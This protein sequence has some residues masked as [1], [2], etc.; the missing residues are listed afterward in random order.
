M[1]TDRTYVRT[2]QPPLSTTPE[3][4][5]QK[6]IIFTITILNAGLLLVDHI[7]FQYNGILIGLLILTFDY[8]VREQY[9]LMTITFSILLLMKHL[10]V[11]FVPIFGLFLIRNYCGFRGFDSRI[12]GSRIFGSVR[13]SLVWFTKEGTHNIHC[14]NNKKNNLNNENAYGEKNNKT[15]DFKINNIDNDNKSIGNDEIHNV[16]NDGID[17][18][19][20]LLDR[21]NESDGANDN[22]YD[23]RSTNDTINSTKEFSSNN[24]NE[25]NREIYMRINAKNNTRINTPNNNNHEYNQ[26]TTGLFI[27]RCSHLVFIALIA[28]FLA[29]GPFILNF[30]VIVKNMNEYWYKTNSPINNI[31]FLNLN[32]VM[33]KSHPYGEYCD[34]NNPLDKC[35]NKIL[36]VIDHNQINQIFTRLVYV[37]I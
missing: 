19:E 12:S 26:P 33:D 6:L 23:D 24:A 28:L 30:S 16:N 25:I 31:D 1:H 34:G 10:F 15:C 29:F 18:K 3:D 8:G 17:K 22:D 21:N 7:H 5:N 11:F 36:T 35:T 14:T 2:V 13:H 37:Y 4:S 20:D 32:F 27:W 9:I